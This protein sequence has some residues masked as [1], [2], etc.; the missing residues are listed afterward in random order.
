M[1]I[2]SRNVEK[3]QQKADALDDTA[4]IKSEESIIKQGKKMDEK[5]V[6]KGEKEARKEAKKEIN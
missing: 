4:I 6:K 3:K 2:T 5:E 1:G